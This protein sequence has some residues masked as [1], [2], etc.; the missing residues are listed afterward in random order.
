[1]ITDI[2]LNTDE[3]DYEDSQKLLNEIAYSVGLEEFGLELLDKNDFDFL[4][5]NTIGILDDDI[6]FMEFK[7]EETLPYINFNIGD[8]FVERPYRTTKR[9]YFTQNNYLINKIVHSMPLDHMCQFYYF[10]DPYHT[11]ICKLTD[12]IETFVNLHNYDIENMSKKQQIIYYYMVAIF[13]CN[14]YYTVIKKEDFYYIQD[15]EGKFIFYQRMIYKEIKNDFLEKIKKSKNIIYKYEK[16]KHIIIIK[17][18]T[19][20]FFKNYQ[21]KHDLKKIRLIN[22]KRI[23][24]FEIGY[25]ITINTD[26]IEK[27]L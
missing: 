26:I 11:K 14:C 18:T 2:N 4:E 13:Y 12:Y 17:P 9:R 20:D 7:G 21:T 3:L 23:K 19:I 6:N 5:D 22:K 10:C 25:D 16:N 27:Y 1:M 24:D 8:I 15:E